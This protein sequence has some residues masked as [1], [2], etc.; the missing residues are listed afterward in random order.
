M[1]DLGWDSSAG[2]Q[3]P[4]PGVVPLPPVH[5]GSQLRQTATRGQAIRAAA[6]G[7]AA[8]ELGCWGGAQG[9]PLGR[10]Q[11]WGQQVGGAGLQGGE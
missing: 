6:G 7:N 9:R 1:A 2:P 4:R 10:G 3:Q 5:C 8:V 11:E